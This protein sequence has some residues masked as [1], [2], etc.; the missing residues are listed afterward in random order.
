MFEFIALRRSQWVLEKHSFG[1]L[2]TTTSITL[3]VIL[4]S[5]EIHVNAPDEVKH[6]FSR[7]TWMKRQT[8]AHVQ[9]G[10]SLAVGSALCAGISLL[11]DDCH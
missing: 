1:S 4:Q 5:A 10:A 7:K 6:A 2:S 11:T 8:E 3:N 9:S